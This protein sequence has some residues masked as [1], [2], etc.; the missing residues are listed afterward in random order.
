M[1]VEKKICARC[2]KT[3]PFDQFYACFLNIGANTKINT[4]MD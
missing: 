2:G 1:R 3:L 4:G